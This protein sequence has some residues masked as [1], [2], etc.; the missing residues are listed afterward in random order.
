[1]SSGLSHHLIPKM[2]HVMNNFHQN[3]PMEQL[4]AF[5]IAFLAGMLTTAV[6][7]LVGNVRKSNDPF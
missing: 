7:T 6:I 5:G 2:E 1:M 4:R 3:S